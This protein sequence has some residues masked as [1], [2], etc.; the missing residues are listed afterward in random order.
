MVPASRKVMASRKEGGRQ[1][2]F[3]VQDINRHEWH[4]IDRRFRPSLDNKSLRTPRRPTTPQ[5]PSKRPHPP[6]PCPSRC[7]RR[8]AWPP[9]RDPPLV[10]AGTPWSPRHGVDASAGLPSAAPRSRHRCEVAGA[11][12]FGRAGGAP[13]E[14]ILTPPFSS[15]SPQV[16][17]LRRPFPGAAAVP[18]CAPRP[19]PPPPSTPPTPDVTLPSPPSDARPWL[20]YCHLSPLPFRERAEHQHEPV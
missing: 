4:E 2:W 1:K 14:S 8:R 12:G 19:P 9:P 13:R 3:E 16:P 15:L 20:T 7:V 18:W 11:R 10:V 17:R 5:L 6:S